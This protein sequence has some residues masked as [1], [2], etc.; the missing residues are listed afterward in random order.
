[1]K[2]LTS[3]FGLCKK[4]KKREREQ[5]IVPSAVLLEVSGGVDVVASPLAGVVSMGVG[6]G[7]SAVEAGA[8]SAFSSV[9]FSA[10]AGLLSSAAGAAGGC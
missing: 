4:E 5:K 1:M 6:A 8:G 2:Y 10:S 9:G 3:E 7:C